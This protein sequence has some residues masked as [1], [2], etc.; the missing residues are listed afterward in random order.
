MSGGP[1]TRASAHTHLVDMVGGPEELPLADLPTRRSVLRKMILEKMQDPR[2]IRNIP[3]MEVAV[4]VGGSVLDAWGKINSKMERA[5]VK[6]KEVARRVFHLWERLLDVASGGKKGKKKKKKYGNQNNKK[7]VFVADLDKLFD[8][9]SCHCTIRTCQELNCQKECEA[10]GKVHITCTCSEE[11]KIPV[12]ELEFIHDQRMKLGVKGKLMIG[13]LDAVETARQVKAK[14]RELLTKQRKEEKEVKEAAKEKELFKR[15]QNWKDQ[16]HLLQEWQDPY[17]EAPNTSSA[18]ESPPGWLNLQNRHHFP[19]TTLAAMRGGV[20]KRTLANLL[21]S[22]AVD[23]GLATRED[24]SLLVDHS[25][26]DRE[27]EREMARVTA[28]AEEWMRSSGINAIQFDGKDEKAKAWVTLECGTKV[29]RHIK[30]DHITLTDSEGEFLMHFTREKVEGVRAGQV[31]AMKIYNFLKTYGIDATLQMIGADSTNL[32]TGCKEG[33]IVLLE[34]Q[35]GRRLVWAICL[36]HTN[37]LP[38]RHL[39]IV[40]DGPTGSGNTLTGP[41]GQLLPHTQS[42]PYNP[43]FPPLS[44]GEPLVSLPPKV[45]ADLSW[46]QQ[47]G[48]KIILALEAGTVPHYLQI[49]VI[50]PVDHSRWLTTANR[51]LDLW[52]RV[53]GLVG[54]DLANLK[55]ICLFILGVYYKMWFA[56]KRSHTLVDGARHML[57]QVQLVQK[58]CSA[59]VK[60]VVEPYIARSSYFAHPELL[61]TPMLA[62]DEEEE[63]RIAVQVIR[64]RIRKGAELGSSQPRQFRAPPVNFLAENLQQLIDWD[65][66]KLTEPLLTANLTSNQL[67]ACLDSPL[68]VPSTWQCHSQSM[69]RAIRKVS[70]SCLM[71]VGEKKREGWIRCAEESRKM[72]KKPNSKADYMSLLDFPLD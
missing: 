54:Q 55:Q 12:L 32:N 22:Y 72:L 67:V 29:M 19:L 42:L 2:D 60:T 1:S 14:E 17:Q 7:E 44:C 66:V 57:K 30:E 53:H 48:Y 51:F 11:F 21:S 43:N 28:K 58:Y 10:T 9:T 31:I 70:E 34:K 6:E 69:E 26:V 61:L 23:L 8:I 36:L 39:I 59:E 56:I 18:V 62:S 71:V 65:K 52:T 35:L 47:Y 27:Q 3:N 46:D 15:Y 64:D 4:K 37:E 16:E 40:L 13:G 38:L 45:V 33:A 25:K 49:M 41:A 68:V 63:R 5:L 20:S 24:P 50:G